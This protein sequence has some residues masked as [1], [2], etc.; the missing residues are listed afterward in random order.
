MFKKEQKLD[1]CL[2]EE[3]TGYFKIKNKHSKIES[4]IKR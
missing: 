4:R 2:S 1:C 3:E